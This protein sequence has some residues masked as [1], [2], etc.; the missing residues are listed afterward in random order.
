MCHYTCASASRAR[1]SGPNWIAILARE[2]GAYQRPMFFAPL[3]IWES[4]G[5]L[6]GNLLGYISSGSRRPFCLLYEPVCRANTVYPEFL[7]F[8]PLPKS[9]HS[10]LSVLTALGTTAMTHFGVRQ[11]RM[12]AHLSSPFD[13]STYFPSSSVHSRTNTCEH[14]RTCRKPSVPI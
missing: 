4:P 10:P 7:R 3:V 6:P 5:R 14:L 8:P 13:P 2:R 12:S 1:K 9:V 11:C